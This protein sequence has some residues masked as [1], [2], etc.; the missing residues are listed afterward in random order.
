MIDWVIAERIAAL[1]AD[2]PMA[3]CRN[4]DLTALAAEAEARVTAY[5]GLVPVRPSPPPEGISRREWVS[6]NIKSMR[7]LLDPV[8]ERAGK[9]LGPLRPAAQIS[10]GLVV[11]TE[12]G[13]VLGYLSQ[14]VLGQYELVLLDEVDEDRRRGCRSRC[15]T[16]A[17]P[18]RRSRPTRKNS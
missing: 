7:V 11:S 14:R 17:R 10:M 5:T 6:S 18:S 8:L 12:V 9:N 4:A 15:P 13:V 3:A 16:S 2:L 1:S